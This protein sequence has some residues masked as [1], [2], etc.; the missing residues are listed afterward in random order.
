M[1]SQADTQSVGV[2]EINLAET[3]HTQTHSQT[4]GV[5]LSGLRV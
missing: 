1:A 2:S 5:S 3:S 4:K